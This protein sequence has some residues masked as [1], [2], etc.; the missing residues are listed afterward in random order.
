MISLRASLHA[1]TS[2]FT[3]V[4]T[5]LI[6]EHPDSLSLMQHL[7]CYSMAEGKVLN[8]VFIRIEISTNRKSI[9]DYLNSCGI[10]NFVT[11][12]FY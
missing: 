3:L 7:R 8:C 11:K 2:G 10:V 6:L 4:F 12:Y 9:N 1:V 5:G